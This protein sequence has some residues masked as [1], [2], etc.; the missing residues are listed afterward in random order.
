MESV[1]EQP[2]WVLRPQ[3]W[4]CRVPCSTTRRHSTSTRTAGGTWSVSTERSLSSAFATWK[5]RTSISPCTITPP[6]VRAPTECP[7]FEAMWASQ[8]WHL[9]EVAFQS[10]L[11]TFHQD[12]IGVAS[13]QLPLSSVIS[14]SKHTEDLFFYKHNRQQHFHI[15]VPFWISKHG[16]QFH[17]HVKLSLRKWGRSSCCYWSICL[18][19]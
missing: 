18:I 7:Y 12:E 16:I 3:V 17:L 15:V 2:S 4:R 5:L 14:L 19:L 9:R 10:S 6:P 11:M 8:L 13:S 1:V